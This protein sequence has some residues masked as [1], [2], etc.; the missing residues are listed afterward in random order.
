[1]ANVMLILLLFFWPGLGGKVNLKYLL[2]YLAFLRLLAFL[3]K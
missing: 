3:H 2:G 1:M